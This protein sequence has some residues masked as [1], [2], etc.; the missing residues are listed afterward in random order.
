M[1]EN[2]IWATVMILVLY[3]TKAFEVPF[4]YPNGYV[5]QTVVYKSGAQR[6]SLAGNVNLDSLCIDCY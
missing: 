5:E 4:R 3:L 6:G 1:E 2:Q